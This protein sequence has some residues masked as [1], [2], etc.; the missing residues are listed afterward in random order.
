MQAKWFVHRRISNSKNTKVKKR[1]L[2]LSKL[3]EES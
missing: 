1:G 3:F 2:K